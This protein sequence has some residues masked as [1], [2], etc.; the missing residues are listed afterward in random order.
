MEKKRIV[1]KSL[2][3]KLLFVLIFAACFQLFALTSLA[4]P[5]FP[6]KKTYVID[7]DEDGEYLDGIVDGMVLG[8]G[9]KITRLKSTKPSVATLYAETYSGKTAFEVGIYHPGTT[10]ITFKATKGKKTYNYKCTITVVCQSDYYESC[11]K[12]VT[13]LGKST[14][15][16]SGKFWDVYDKNYTFKSKKFTVASNC[17]VVYTSYPAKTYSYSSFYK[18]HKTVNV[19]NYYFTGIT[20][21]KGK[22][23][24]FRYGPIGN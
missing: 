12:T 24:E 16:V 14:I 10:V 8:K 2:W 17:K 6:T 23:V 1:L 3:K 18:K 7:R 5:S 15:T 9:Y 19:A 11:Y 21:K 13:K 4:K 22:V 20:L